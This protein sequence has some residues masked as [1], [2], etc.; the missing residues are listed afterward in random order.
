MKKLILFDLD[1]TLT[2][3]APGITRSVQYALDKMGYPAYRE[4]EL[5]TFIGPPLNVH[6]MEFCG[7]SDEEA[8]VG[9]RYF[10][11]RFESVGLYENS[12]YEGVA[13]MLAALKEAGAVIGLATSKPEPFAI[14]IAEHL[15][16]RKYL[17]VLSAATLDETK[18]NKPAIIGKA[19]RRAGFLEKK[20]DA[21]MVGDRRF[22]IRGA[23]ENGL[24]ALGVLY[25]Y[26]SGEELSEAGA[27]GMVSTV[28]E[29]KEVLLAWLSG[30]QFPEVSR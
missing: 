5:R 28:E 7:M 16:F 2:D 12:L 19:L 24:R 4:E 13:K 10:R 6:F 8:A 9:V 18:D 21:L 29:T 17:D 14:R 27:D 20:G 25:G 23:H 15:G 1:G 26:G 11:E 3:S 22:D 30:E